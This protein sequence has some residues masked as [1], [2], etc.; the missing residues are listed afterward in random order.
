MKQ[1]YASVQGWTLTGLVCALSALGCQEAYDENVGSAESEIAS[2]SDDI[3][4]PT[5]NAVVLNTSSGCTGTLVAP[6]IVLTA[7]HCGYLNEV[8]VSNDGGWYPLS[9]P[10]TIAFGPDRNNPVFTT[11]A[12]SISGPAQNGPRSTRAITDIVLLRLED[13][14]PRS[15]AIPRSI[16]YERP[17]DILSSRIVQVGYGGGRDRRY[18]IGDSYRDWTSSDPE[19][20]HA[21]FRYDPFVRGPGIGTRDTNIEGGD[22]GGPMLYKT[23]FGP[24]LGVLSHWKP[25]GIATFA[26]SGLDKKSV[27]EWLEVRLPQPKP[28]LLKVQHT[29]WCSGDR[30]VVNVF[31]ENQGVADSAATYVDFFIGHPASPSMGDIGDQWKRVPIMAPLMQ[32]FF[33]FT[34]A[35][36]QSG[37]QYWIDVIVDTDRVVDESVENNNIST[38]VVTLPNCS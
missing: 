5:A 35:P 26:P 30:P 36:E 8:G 19:L 29:T 12:T 31:L 15:K 24:V 23:V 1:K 34:L 20:E 9:S 22:S 10:Q 28:D 2:G 33:A 38:F 3:G 27:R 13:S 32:R 37:G 7:A 21:E 18:L 14:V 16:L 11:T 4:G 6:N 17:T 25:T